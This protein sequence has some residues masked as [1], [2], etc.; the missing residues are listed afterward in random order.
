MKTYWDRQRE[1]E[2]V[3]RC[4]DHFPIDD[5]QEGGLYD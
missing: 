2:V 3:A 4:G 5:W 1:T